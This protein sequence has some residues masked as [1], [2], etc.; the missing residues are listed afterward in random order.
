VLTEE[1]DDESG[2]STTHNCKAG[3]PEI[4]LKEIIHG[5]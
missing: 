5:E 2:N 4:H 1:N 3:N